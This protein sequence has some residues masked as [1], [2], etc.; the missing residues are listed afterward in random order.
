MLEQYRALGTVVLHI[1]RYML[2]EWR[3]RMAGAVDR[4]FLRLVLEDEDD[5]EWPNTIFF[6]DQYT[7]PFEVAEQQ[8][9]SCSPNLLTIMSSL[10][11]V[12]KRK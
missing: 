1:F 7:R 3:C 9:P 6:M 10:I 8:L 12:W 5:G 4:E 11:S 2:K